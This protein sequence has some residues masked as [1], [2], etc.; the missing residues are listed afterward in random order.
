MAKETKVIT[1]RRKF[2][3]VE[4]PST[5]AKIELVG[6]TPEDL[7]DKTI[8][9]DLTRDLRGK[10]MEAVV[11]VFIEK[12]KA[13]A[14]PIK[15]RLMPYFIRRMIRKRISY[16]EDSFETP[17]QESMLRI[18]PFLITRKRVSR[19]VRKTLR[20]KAKNWLEDYISQKK[21]K[22]LFDEILTNRLQKQL[23]IHLKKTYPLSLCEIR[24]LE[25]KRPLKSKE[26]PKKIKK[27]IS[28]EDEIKKQAETIQE[29]EVIDQLKEIEDEKIKKAQEEIKKTQEKAAKK[30]VEN[31]NTKNSEQDDEEKQ[32]SEEPISKSDK[33]EDTKSREDT[34]KK[35]LGVLDKTLKT[36]ETKPKEDKKEK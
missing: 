24:V 29:P 6:T 1:R 10:S 27:I 20:N 3:E 23:S 5:R 2:I 25:I 34:S 12:E 9:L 8:K 4:I 33:L 17:S 14:H 26:I 36:K 18:K 19:V 30:E 35:P 31:K 15:I 7:K 11:K 22:E 16:V 13:V 32:D 28:K 21:D